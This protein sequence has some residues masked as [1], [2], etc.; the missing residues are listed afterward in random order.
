MKILIVD[1]EIPFQLVEILRAKHDVHIYADAFENDDFYKS[2]R[3]H[4]ASRYD[5]VTCA[6]AL[7][8]AAFY[9]LIIVCE[10]ILALVDLLNN[11]QHVIGWRKYNP[12]EKDKWFFKKTCTD[13]GIK[14]PWCFGV[15]LQSPPTMEGWQDTPIM[16][17]IAD[18]TKCEPR[19]FSY[20]A[21]TLK[22]A[23]AF[24]NYCQS[25]V[26]RDMGFSDGTSLMLEQYIRG[27][28]VGVG[29][30][31]NG[32]NFI[33]PYHMWFE[34]KKLCAGDV[35]PNIEEIG[36]VCHTITGAFTDE[37]SPY[38][39]RLV[40]TLKKFEAYL[41]EAN[42]VGYFDLNAITEYNTGDLY[43]LECDARFPNPGLLAIRNSLATDDFARA[44]KYLHRLGELHISPNVWSVVGSL[45]T[46][47]FPWADK[48]GEHIG[49]VMFTMPI[50]TDIVPNNIIH[51]CDD[52]WSTPPPEFCD[53][54]RIADAIGSASTCDEA[55]R[56][57]LE[58]M[59]SIH[60]PFGMWRKDIGASGS[61]D[62]NRTIMYDC[63]RTERKPQGVTDV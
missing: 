10:P 17:K 41:R 57:W 7:I 48:V 9:D 15:N 51:R 40:K 21:A 36:V 49:N 8:R 52:I 23:K 19:L 31:F 54:G 61:R 58:K 45:V 44:L 32:T 2:M 29:A 46:I 13:L 27:Q 16:V 12:I 26:G 39:S 60:Y 18:Q 55:H 53:F 11:H 22:D 38:Y 62:F 30:F 24:I 3:G 63:E 4:Y 42:Y 14:V 47:G 50:D 1:Q 56:I 37:K 25:A 35:G 5:L 28:E 34:Y 20:H 59:Q 43:V 6:D 33:A